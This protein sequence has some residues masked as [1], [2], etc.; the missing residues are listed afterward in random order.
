[1]ALLAKDV[2]VRAM[3]L[4]EYDVLGPNFVTRNIIN[5]LRAESL[6]LIQRSW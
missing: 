1:V 2:M 4:I 6:L 5:Q 3:E